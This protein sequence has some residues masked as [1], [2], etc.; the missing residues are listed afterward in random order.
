MNILFLLLS[1]LLNLK[2][3][4]GSENEIKP[5]NHLIKKCILKELIMNIEKRTQER[6]RQS[7]SKEW[8]YTEKQEQ[9]F[10]DIWLLDDS[11]SAEE[12]FILLYQKMIESRLN[13]SNGVTNFLMKRVLQDGMNQKSVY[14]RTIGSVLGF[15]TGPHYNPVFN[16]IM[17]PK[18]MGRKIVDH[19]VLFH[20]IEH[21]YNRNTNPLNIIFLTK[22]V[23]KE[24]FM[25]IPTPFT[26]I[27]KLHIEARAIGAQWE[28]VRRIP[29]DVRDELVHMLE[30]PHLGEA[31]ESFI[32]QLV[33]ERFEHEAKSILIKGLKNFRPPKQ[34]YQITKNGKIDDIERFRAYRNY[35]LSKKKEI[36]KNFFSNADNLLEEK[37]EKRVMK[38]F[39]DRNF[40]GIVDDLE[41]D[42]ITMQRK[43]F[44]VSF[45][46]NNQLEIEDADQ[47]IE[48][49][50]S[51]Y[52]NKQF[53]KPRMHSTLEKIRRDKWIQNLMKQSLTDLLVNSLKGAD[54]SKGEFIEKISPIHG[55]DLKGLLKHHYRF[56]VMKI[57]LVIATLYQFHE[58]SKKDASLKEWSQGRQF[59]A[60]DIHF[61]VQ[62]FSW[63][64]MPDIENEQVK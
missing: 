6:I 21:A 30:L 24:L 58:I 41:L 29:K 33:L 9:S 59:T 48:I 63:L 3:S 23:M 2:L 51:I 17:L 31:D 35:F 40:D 1:L 56:S 54:L 12:K 14:A 36:I 53:F 26:P 46:D 32:S 62:F 34:E 18:T 11:I 22:V 64:F 15:F 57:T 38:I 16:R 44:K 55:Y 27:A 61:I 20:E 10:K 43:N 13:N 49:I 4:I 7:A 28:L 19:F 5:Q 42:L 25:I 60:Y 52:S 8:L 50:N 39:L 37:V 45:N 47:V